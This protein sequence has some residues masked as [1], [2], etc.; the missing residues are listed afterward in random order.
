MDVISVV[1]LVLAVIGWLWGR[2]IKNRNVAMASVMSYLHNH[3][4]FWFTEHQIYKKTGIHPAILDTVLDHLTEWNWVE[5]R[6]EGEDHLFRLS[7]YMKQR[8]IQP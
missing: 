1:F 8:G 7:E 5:Q 6:V 3:P 4:E 2:H